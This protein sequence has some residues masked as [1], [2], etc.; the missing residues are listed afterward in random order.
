MVS[1]FG[2]RRK[3][4]L[5]ESQ[6]KVLTTNLKQVCDV[7][8]TLADINT[9]KFNLLQARVNDLSLSTSSNIIDLADDIDK[10]NAK[11]A[12]SKFELKK[13]KKEVKVALSNKVNIKN[14]C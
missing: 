4:L 9:K 14:K 11:A 1:L 8:D 10:L 6:I 2:I 13:Y 7:Y 12:K 5:L 3:R